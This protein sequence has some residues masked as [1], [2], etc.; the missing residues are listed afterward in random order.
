MKTKEE[1]WW[2]WHWDKSDV[3]AVE[4][5]L[6]PTLALPYERIT[7]WR[8]GSLLTIYRMEAKG[9]LQWWFYGPFNICFGF[10]YPI[11]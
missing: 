11:K 1:K 9:N 10:G 7:R 6:A 8:R 4:G 5:S 3:L 2:T